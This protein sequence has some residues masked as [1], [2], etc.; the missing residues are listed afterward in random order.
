MVA[1]LSI[2]EIIFGGNDQPGLIKRTQ[3]GVGVFRRNAQGA[4]GET[5]FAAVQLLE[6]TCHGFRRC[7]KE[8]PQLRLDIQLPFCANLRFLIICWRAEETLLGGCHALWI[9]ARRDLAKKFGKKRIQLGYLNL[10]LASANFHINR[11][12]RVWRAKDTRAIAA[13]KVRRAPACRSTKPNVL[14]DAPPTYVSPLSRVD[15]RRPVGK[16][17]LHRS[18]DSPDRCAPPLAMED[19]GLPP[20]GFRVRSWA[21]QQSRVPHFSYLETAYSLRFAPFPPPP[22]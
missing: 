7:L 1:Q 13:H 9:S 17:S 15:S 14:F 2:G 6:V 20:A 19:R 8:A 21:D 22:P 5:F 18:L 3:P 4:I 12:F 10:V 11:P 16:P